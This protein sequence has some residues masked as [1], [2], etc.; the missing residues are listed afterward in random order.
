[1]EQSEFGDDFPIPSRRGGDKNPDF[2]TPRKK[3]FI[4]PQE[5]WDM[6]NDFDEI[7]KNEER[8]DV[9]PSCRKLLDEVSI[10]FN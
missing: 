5:L 4:I 8:D 10:Q 2:L 9:A 3:Q 7:L 1:M 6:W